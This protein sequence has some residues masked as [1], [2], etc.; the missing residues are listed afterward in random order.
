MSS[1][2]TKGAQTMSDFWDRWRKEQM[3]MLVGIWRG[4]ARGYDRLYETEKVGRDAAG[5][6]TYRAAA[7]AYERCADELERMIEAV[8]VGKALAQSEE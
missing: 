1:L 4:E 6:G 3:L 5:A 8:S 2:L 7:I